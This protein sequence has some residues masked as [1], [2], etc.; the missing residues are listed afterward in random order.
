MNLFILYLAIHTEVPL[1]WSDLL[2]D[3]VFLRYFCKDSNHR[4]KIAVVAI[5][6]TYKHS[7]LLL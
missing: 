7:Y 5:L 4:R 1:A 3:H 6:K 2:T